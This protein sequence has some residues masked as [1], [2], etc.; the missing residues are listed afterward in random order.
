MK[1]NSIITE[2][3]SINMNLLKDITKLVLSKLPSIIKE[4]NDITIYIE[5]SELDELIKKYPEKTKTIKYFDDLSVVFV[6]NWMYINVKTYGVYEPELKRVTINVAAISDKTTDVTLKDLQSA[7]SDNFGLLPVLVHELRH[8]MQYA[9]FYDYSEKS[10]TNKGYKS[11]DIEIDAAWHDHLEMFDPKD[12][13][14]PS[15]YALQVMIK[16][17]D[18]RNL[19]KQQYDHYRK[20]TIKY[21]INNKVPQKSKNTR[22]RFE[23]Y[24][25]NDLP[26][27]IAKQISNKNNILKDFDLRNLPN[28][29]SDSFLLPMQIIT[30]RLLKILNDSETPSN[31]F[32]KNMLMLAAALVIPGD[33]K[34]LKDFAKYMKRVHNYTVSDMIN[35]IELGLTSDTKTK[36][37]FNSIKNYIKTQYG[38]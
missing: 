10:R 34:K 21:F 33:T 23:K 12:F 3:T 28:Y 5:D 19:T 1:I 32:Q 36:F 9:E 4:N 30:P 25:T 15:L 29:N 7:R 35:S 13:A 27:Y 16:F 6:H 17:S 26:K 14:S 38:I 22:E 2:A 37:D 20:K 31:D 18:T 24:I 8:A 11:R